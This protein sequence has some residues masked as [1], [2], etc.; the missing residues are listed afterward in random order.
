MHGF[1]NRLLLSTTKIKLHLVLSS[2]N[3]EIEM[4]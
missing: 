4:V 3:D 1:S 2:K